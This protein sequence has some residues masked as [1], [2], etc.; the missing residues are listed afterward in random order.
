M[1]DPG[2]RHSSSEYRPRPVDPEGMELEPH[3]RGL[4]EE[5]AS[6]NHDIWAWNRQRE[7]WSLGPARDDTRK[8]HPG[9]VPYAELSDS[10]KQY[11]RN[12]AA[13]TISALRRLGYGVVPPEIPAALAA[14]D[15]E[16]RVAANLEFIEKNGAAP[17]VK[18]WRAQPA[19]AWSEPKPYEKL[20]AK[21]VREGE[22]VVGYEVA[23][24]GLRRWPDN[25][26]L[27]HAQ[28]L[29]LARVGATSRAQ[30][31]ALE[32]SE[33][34][35]EPSLV[36][37]SISL[38]ARTHKDMAF[39]P[40][41]P[42]DQREHL[43]RALAAYRRAEISGGY[44]AAINAATLALL[45]GEH[46]A[47]KASARV[48][49]ERA[50][51]ELRKAASAGGAAPA[52]FYWPLA[53]L[54]E[55]AVILGDHREARRRYAE[56]VERAAGSYGDV[57]AMRRQLRLLTGA[58]GV[59]EIEWMDGVFRMPKVVLF[60]GQMW[61]APGGP[62]ESRRT[63][64]EDR[65]RALGAG[66]GYSSAARGAEIL[67]LESM[68]AIGGKSY[69]V[70]PYPD[71]QF[72]RKRI[73]TRSNGEWAL[74]YERAT[75][76]AVEVLTASAGWFDDSA[77]VDEYS[78]LLLEGLAKIHSDVLGTE[79]VRMAVWDGREDASTV[80]A[81]VR[82]WRENKHQVEV[83]DPGVRARKTS[84]PSVETHREGRVAAILFADVVGF[85][86]LPNDLDVYQFFRV[87]L[88]EVA[89]LL[90]NPDHQTMVRNTWGD[91]LYLVF[92]GVRQA[93][94]F[95]LQLSRMVNE[96]MWRDRGLSQ[97][98]NVRVAVHAGPLLKFVDPVTGQ[99]TLSGKHVTRAARME[100][101]TPP[102]LVYASREFAALAAAEG[103]QEFCCEPVGRLQLDK[104]AGLASLFVVTATAPVDSG[105]PLPSAKRP[106]KKGKLSA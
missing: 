37:D 106:R 5:L 72:V 26:W 25:R 1:S 40:C 32:L 79:L 47:A 27:Q 81:T 3:L 49:R 13:S 7:G 65:L 98:L 44:Y 18:A 2:E 50:E 103:V 75:A 62:S 35:D 30:A 99:P 34:R 85:S 92:P 56:A 51:V 16:S 57:A 43:G 8:L 86:K 95:A 64:I 15:R 14:E 45:L 73:A 9:L 60:A 42:R 59:G 33:Q 88:G 94:R 58:N 90:E 12:A 69:V 4:I 53:T 48:A 24:E 71:E 31:I 68:T 104:R 54:G 87:F 52:E 93:G 28:G 89:S 22:P 96:T 77:L 83:I 78:S 11:D 55:A 46:D 74:R 10:E 97:D 17:L 38:L 105:A 41:T 84:R 61:D 91:G 36:E 80:S 19:D 21:L 82:R 67:F 66:F 102:G 101:V 29:A 76:E 63:A 23:I 70:L 39:K 6:V 100:P 20:A